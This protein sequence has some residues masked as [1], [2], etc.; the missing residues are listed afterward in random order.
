VSVD[1]ISDHRLGLPRPPAGRLGL[2]RSTS[3]YSHTVKQ[4]ARVSATAAV[5]ALAAASDIVSGDG[6]AGALP[7][8]TVGAGCG[9]GG[10]GGGVGGDCAAGSVLLAVALCLNFKNGRCSRGDRCRFSHDLTAPLPAPARARAPAR[11]AA[12][13]VARE[14]EAA[15]LGGERARGVALCVGFQTGMCRRGTRC[16]FLHSHAPSP[17]PPLSPPPEAADLGGERARGVALCVGFQTGMCRRGTRCKFLHSHAPSSPPPLSPPPEAADL[18]GERARGVALCVGFQTG[19]C[20]RGTRCKFLHSH[21]P[22]PPPPPLPAVPV[23]ASTAPTRPQ[24]LAA[25]ECVSFGR[26]ECRRGDRCRFSHARGGAGIGVGMAGRPVGDTPAVE[27]LLAAA[28]TGGAGA[29]DAA[30]A[31]TS[32]P[33]AA[34]ISER[35]GALLCG[36]LP[37]TPLPSSQKRRRRSNATVNS[38]DFLG[39]AGFEAGRESGAAAA[40]AAAA[41]AA[42]LAAKKAEKRAR[43]RAKKAVVDKLHIPQAASLA[44]TSAADGAESREITAAISPSAIVATPS[45]V[46][47]RPRGERGQLKQGGDVLDIAAEVWKSEMLLGQGKQAGSGC[48]EEG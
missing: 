4:A 40:E 27:A 11:G 33:A 47:H 14:A 30:A 5:S 1:P 18:G 15:D 36:S 25:A 48:W 19:M 31:T 9:G 37:P 34:G 7:S 45:I 46:E 20:R 26:G 16:K 23:A 21:A 17:P 22:S 41:A 24:L 35:E 28:A 38:P 44:G 32:L 13:P 39:A 8:P 2:C 43:K 42:A 3:L 10:G 6:M 12:A 29:W